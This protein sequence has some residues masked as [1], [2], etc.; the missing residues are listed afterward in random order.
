MAIRFFCDQIA[1][2]LKNQRLLK[3]WIKSAIEE[4]GFKLGEIN[5]ILCNDE[6]LLEIN[7]KFL[8]HDFYTDIITFD[9]S[10]DQTISGEL[11]ISL[12]RVID[13][14]IK[15]REN[16]DV[17]LYRIVIHGFMHLC[18]YKDKSDAEQIQMRN[19]EEKYLNKYYKK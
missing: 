3:A 6:F 12:E 17:E 4:E 15:N 8:Q 14:A 5:V 10:Q 19:I 1:Y 11:Y 13:N 9:Y 2:K 18:G 16:I 7:Q